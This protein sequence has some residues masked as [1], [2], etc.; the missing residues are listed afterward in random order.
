MDY[1]KKLKERHDMAKTQL[2]SSSSIDAIASIYTEAMDYYCKTLIPDFFS[3]RGEGKKIKDMYQKLD[4]YQYNTFVRESALEL[5]DLNVASC[6]YQDYLNGM[7][8][9]I[10]E[11][12]GCCIDGEI[13]AKESAVC[14]E[15]LASARVND[16]K[17]IES[18]F[19]G[20]NNERHT[21][22][23]LEA[24]KN[25]E[26]LIDFL[27]NIKEES[28][29]CKNTIDKIKDAI[30]GGNQG[31]TILI[32]SAKLMTESMNDYV[33]H[34]ISEIFESYQ[35]INEVLETRNN[36]VTKPV[37]TAEYTVW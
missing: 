29:R 34:A 1:V 7:R 18:I 8:T 23:V 21:E 3:S 6:A 24:A 26:F 17:F 33:Y 10:E 30:G 13:Y 9:F 32:E 4:K 31:E 5:V 27:G 25:V 16:G 2:S 20:C 11:T 28:T 36:F 37:V 35:S 12:C 14:G 15:K 22:T 19:G